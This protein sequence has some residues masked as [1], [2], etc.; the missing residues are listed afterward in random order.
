[1]NG[2]SF[3]DYFREAGPYY[4]YSTPD[5][6]WWHL[7]IG[8]ARKSADLP[9]WLYPYRERLELELDGKTTSGTHYRFPGIGKFI[10]VRRQFVF[11]EFPEAPRATEAGSRFGK[12]VVEL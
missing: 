11:E 4:R 9:P 7:A 1:M 8:F 10:R 5:G 3:D 6:L 2:K 12:L